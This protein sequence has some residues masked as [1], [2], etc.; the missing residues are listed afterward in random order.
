MQ[1]YQPITE[2][3]ILK[4]IM[5]ETQEYRTNFRGIETLYRLENDYYAARY[6]I[7]EDF[8]GCPSVYDVLQNA[9]EMC[10]DNEGEYD[11]VQCWKSAVEAK[12]RGEI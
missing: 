6:A 3:E 7:Y 8:S 12:I 4:A 1:N 10:E 11:C 5:E 9:H 2:A